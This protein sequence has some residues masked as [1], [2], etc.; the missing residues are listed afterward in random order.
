MKGAY[1]DART[2]FLNGT[3][4]T[5]KIRTLLSVFGRPDFAFPKAKVALF[6]DGCFW[7]GCRKC[8][9]LPKRSSAAASFW[10]EKIQRNVQ[11]DFRVSRHLRKI[12]WTVLRAKECAL[13]NPS[14]F[15]TRL[16]AL[17]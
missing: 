9:R 14:R 11:R 4:R 3:L 2:G 16:K 17:V 12:G 7:H 13:R 10:F 15:L 1:Y 5:Y 8:N 6:I